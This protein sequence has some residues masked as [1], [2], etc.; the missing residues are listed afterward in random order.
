MTNQ[1][2]AAEVMETHDLF[3]FTSGDGWMEPYEDV[4]RCACGEEFFSHIQT[5]DGSGDD[6]RDPNLLYR[7]HLAQALADAGLLIPDLPA[8]DGAEE[9]KTYWYSSTYGIAVGQLAPGGRQNV[10][11]WDSEPGGVAYMGIEGA[12][13]LA[14]ALLAAAKLAEEQ[15]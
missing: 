10:I 8:P 7:Q 15:E 14:Y 5:G 12:R 3:H 1:E 2:R 13:E 9:G 6:D 4:I 11:F